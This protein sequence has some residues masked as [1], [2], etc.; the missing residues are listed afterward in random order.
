M[1]DSI[2]GYCDLFFTGADSAFLVRGRPNSEIFLS[3]IRELFQRVQF[4]VVSKSS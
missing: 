2:E 1:D 4:F 3:D